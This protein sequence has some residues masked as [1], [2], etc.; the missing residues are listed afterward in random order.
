LIYI[1]VTPK[2]NKNLL[3]F[4]QLKVFLNKLHEEDRRPCAAL[5]KP[6]H[7]ARAANRLRQ[8]LRPEDPKDLEKKKICQQD[9]FRQI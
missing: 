5:P 4:L 7:I 3:A 1:S 9:S 6:E 8:K 2:T